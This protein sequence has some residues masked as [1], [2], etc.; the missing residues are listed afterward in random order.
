MF[1]ELE[2]M[3]LEPSSIAGLPGVNV[4]YFRDPKTNL[5]LG[6]NITTP[7]WREDLTISVADAFEKNT[8]WNSWRNK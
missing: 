2:D 3:F 7:M 4:P 8:E 6:M 1:G 5:Y